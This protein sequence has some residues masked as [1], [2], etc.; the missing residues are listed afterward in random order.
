MYIK[1]PEDMLSTKHGIDS[2]TTTQAAI[3]KYWIKP[4][5]Y[6]QRNFYLN[7]VENTLIRWFQIRLSSYLICGLI[8]PI[9]DLT[10]SNWI[11]GRNLLCLIHRYRPELL[12]DLLNQLEIDKFDYTDGSAN[13]R[14]RRSDDQANYSRLTNACS[15]LSE[16]FSINFN[17]K[18]GSYMIHPIQQ[19]HSIGYNQ[20]KSIVCPKSNS[21]WIIYLYNIYHVFSQLKL[22]MSVS[23][24]VSAP[25]L[26]KS[27]SV[28]DVHKS[29]LPTYSSSD[30]VNLR[31]TSVSNFI[32]R[33]QRNDNN[34]NKL[35]N[36]QT[37]T[38]VNHTPRSQSH[39]EN[40]NG[41]VERGL[42]TKRREEL[43]NM[44][45]KIIVYIKIFLSKTDVI[46]NIQNKQKNVIL[47][48]IRFQVTSL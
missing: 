39:R 42:T 47:I 31:K 37:L 7:P 20:K 24:I 28:I 6:E 4:E 46:H 26:T 1:D 13:R 17:L 23:T 11:C 30:R 12:P 10:P 21:D 14:R 34:I 15:L 29:R 9:N 38:H 5:H 3:Q 45:K 25:V 8:D 48:D 43:I 35:I 2:P 22:P 19:C 32:P 27:S 18:S 40:L 33:S 44:L 36:G 16:H 41:I